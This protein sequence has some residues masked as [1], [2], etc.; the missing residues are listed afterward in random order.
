VPDV[1]GR[2]LVLGS[3]VY[4][5]IGVMP[6]GFAFP[7]RTPPPLVWTTLADDAEGDHPLITQRGLDLL[8]VIGR[9]K[10]RVSV[11]RARSDLDGVI[12]ELIKT[13]PDTNGLHNAAVVEPELEHLTGD[14]RPAL[15]LSFAA[16]ILLLIIACVNVAGLALARVTR[17]QPEMALR[18]SL[19]AS[20]GGIIR[21]VLAESI[22][23]SLLGGIGGILLSEALLRGFLLLRL[24]K[25]S[26]GCSRFQ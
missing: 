12:H 25:T 21:L 19:G 4:T 9:L 2:S 18:L 13:F 20:R 3:Y 26:P 24:N 7:F 5:I 8:E 22:L 17:R 14:T 11:E 1:I 10:P 23:L 6:A 15:R 16:V